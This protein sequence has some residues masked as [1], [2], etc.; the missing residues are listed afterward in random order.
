MECR[1]DEIKRGR[2]RPK[3]KSGCDGR[4]EVRIGHEER[5][6]ID[7]MIIESDKS[8]SDLV[9]KAIMLYYR[10]HKGRW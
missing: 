9:R 1:D 7:H 8:K 6:A 4:L 2:G 5:A 10:T 3:I